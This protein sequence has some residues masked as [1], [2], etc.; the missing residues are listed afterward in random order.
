MAA[1]GLPGRPKTEVSP[2]LPTTIGFPGRSATRSGRA[3]PPAAWM[4]RAVWS[5][6]LPAA[7]PVLTMMSAWPASHLSVPASASI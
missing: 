1:T 3:R 6:S 2:I 5:V 7:P 4:A